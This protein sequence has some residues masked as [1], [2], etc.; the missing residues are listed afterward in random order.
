MKK[1][2]LLAA[3]GALLVTFV[4]TD[5]VGATFGR[6]RTALRERLTANVPLRTQLAEARAQVDAYA[7]SVIKG[8]VAAERLDATIARVDREVATLAAKVERDRDGLLALRRDLEAVPVSSAG[9]PAAQREALQRSRQFRTLTTLL[10]RRRADL[11]RLKAERDAT[12]RSVT[13]AKAEQV[14]LN[15]EIRVL[16][17]EIESLE[18]RTAAARTREAVGD[19]GLS[20]SGYAKATERLDA[21]RAQILEKNKRLQY[22]E[23]ER[24]ALLEDGDL[25]VEEGPSDALSA[26]ESALLTVP[27]R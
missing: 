23:V 26:V 5:V 27:A 4:G 15:Q 1:L 14:R 6:A 18:A 25:L 8:E 20:S 10:E 9:D 7:E 13:E 22:Y 16:A 17:A 3:A 12:L 21:L 19:A 24:G 2:F 11:E